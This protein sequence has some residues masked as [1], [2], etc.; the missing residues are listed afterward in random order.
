MLEP[1]QAGGEAIV[2]YGGWSSFI[3]YPILPYAKTWLKQ[4][5]ADLA[6]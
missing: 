2:D 3:S 4:V 1:F 5:R 6:N